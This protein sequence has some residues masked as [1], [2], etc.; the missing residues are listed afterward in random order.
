MQPATPTTSAVPAL[1]R[2]SDDVLRRVILRLT[3]PWHRLSKLVLSCTAL[4][5]YVREVVFDESDRLGMEPQPVET[6]GSLII[7]MWNV[8]YAKAN[9]QVEA[10]FT[11]HSRSGDTNCKPKHDDSWLI[12]LDCVRGNVSARHHTWEPKH[13]IALSAP[14]ERFVVLDGRNGTLTLTTG[15]LFDVVWTTSGGVAL[16][17]RVWQEVPSALPLSSEWPR[18]AALVESSTTKLDAFASMAAGITGSPIDKLH[19]L[20]GQDTPSV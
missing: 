6:T 16:V 3:P 11:L 13:W 4:H 19:I 5:F 14:H 2:L 8:K 15:A 17:R 1:L 7:A 10:R 12:K 18:K 9:Y 20:I